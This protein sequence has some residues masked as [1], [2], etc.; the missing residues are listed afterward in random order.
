MKRWIPI[1]TAALIAGVLDEQI[2]SRQC[3]ACG[4]AWQVWNLQVHR[5][6]PC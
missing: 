3:V 1:G 5:G 6:D 2:F 4:K